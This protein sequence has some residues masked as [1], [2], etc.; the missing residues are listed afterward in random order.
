MKSRLL[1]TVVGLFVLASAASWTAQS[2]VQ[3]SCAY[4]SLWGISGEK[5]R[6]EG[7]LP[8]FSYAGYHAGEA[9]IPNP[10]AKWDFK[11]DFHAK[12]DGHTDDFATLLNAIKSIDRG[13]LFIP[14]GTY[15][16][17]KRIAISKSNSG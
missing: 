14:Q 16:F 6:A 8:D 17:S 7:R 2:E 11:R 10:P 9:S 12:G 3:S 5:W 1:T 4:S 15:A 13:V